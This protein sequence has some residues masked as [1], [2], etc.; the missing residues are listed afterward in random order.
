MRMHAQT[1]KLETGQV[2][3]PELADW[4]DEFKQE[5]CARFPTD[6]MTIR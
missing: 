2:F 1:G 5:V 4:L 3:L 6:H